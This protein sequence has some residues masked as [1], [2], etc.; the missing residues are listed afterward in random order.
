MTCPKSVA[1]SWQHEYPLEEFPDF[2]EAKKVSIN[3]SDVLLGYRNIRLLFLNLLFNVVLDPF[4]HSWVVARILL[5]AV[6][7]PMT[8]LSIRSLGLAP[9]QALLDV[10]SLILWWEVLASNPSANALVSYITYGTDGLILATR[11]L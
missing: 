7:S 10:I 11:I 3:T 6:S 4:T 8:H 2:L 1:N 5:L 9:F